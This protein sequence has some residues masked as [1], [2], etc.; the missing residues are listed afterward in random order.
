MK[1]KRGILAEMVFFFVILFFSAGESQEVPLEKSAGDKEV[2]RSLLPEDSERPGW[3]ATSRPEFFTSQNLWEYIN[4][5]AEMYID[6]GFR[7]VVTIEYMCSDGAGSMIIEVF[8][9]QSPIHAFGI[10]AAERSPDDFFIKMGAQGY[11]G[12]NA[13]N[14]WKG[15]YYVKLTASRSSSDTKKALMMLGNTIANKIEGSF[16]EPALF[17]C[18]PQKN[19]VKMSER[20]IPKN[21]LGQAF[22]EN[23]YRVEYRDGGTTYQIF[24]I[25]TGSR[26]K[27]TEAFGKYQDF[28][29]S[30]NEKISLSKRD[31]YQLFFTQGEEGKSVFKYSSFV[32]GILNSRDSSEAE[33]T[34]EEVVHKLKP[35]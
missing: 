5:Q 17:A 30:R 34:I 29:R 7:C 9:M 11:L 27:A 6:Y 26:E 8:Q 2:L 3:R 19:R 28:L 33:R 16:S 4:G 21:F 22:L 24:L 14:F 35:Q 18:F 1:R 15:P 25:Q 10:Y 20:F 31:D 32:G 13:L 12:E 23:G